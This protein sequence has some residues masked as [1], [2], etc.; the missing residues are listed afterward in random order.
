[1]KRNQRLPWVSV[2]FAVLC[3]TNSHAQTL[4]NPPQTSNLDSGLF[5][6]ILTGE[7]SAQRGDAGT[8]ISLLLDAARKS[9]TPKL[10]ER[11]VEVA[12][13]NRAGDLALQAA[14]A[15]VA[16]M[17]DSREANRY[18]LQILIGLNRLPEVVAP[19][20]RELASLNPEDRAKSLENL[21]RFFSNAT[22]KKLA[23]TVVEQALAAD[24]KNA[25]TGPLAWTIVGSMRLDAADT[26]GALDAAKSGVA[27]DKAAREPI[28][29]ALA[30]LQSNPAGAEGL[31]LDYLKT[32]HD[33]KMQMAYIRRL[34]DAQ[35]FA[36]VGL[37]IQQLTTNAPEFPDAWLVRSSL[38]LQD[39]R[40]AIARLSVNNYLYTM[41][42]MA[43]DI[44]PA[45]RERG[46]V[47]AYFLLS[48]I[49]EMEGNFADAE[50]YLVAI[51]TEQDF[52][53]VQIR[54]ASL[55][56]KQGKLNDAIAL[57]LAIPEKREEDARNKF[58][59]HLQLLRDNGQH[60]AAYALLADVAK[61]RPMDLDLTYELAM[62]AEKI[63]RL[64]EMETYLRQIIAA[65]PEYHSAYNA[66]G[67]VLAD[68]NKRLPEAHA[69]ITK[70]L[71]LAPDNAYILDSLGWV[72]F[73]SGNL[74]KAVQLLQRAFDTKPDAEIAAHLGE[75]LWQ[76]GR[77]L[78]ARAMWTKGLLLNANNE[79]LNET[80]RRLDRP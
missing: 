31:V 35:R 36:D 52:A 80:I 75:V 16:A 65:N 4:A 15:W 64:D 3:V 13:R 53:N 37:Q 44:E 47:Q 41:K 55:L 18:L 71:Q 10:F 27:L 20:K 59:A 22:D 73:R 70:A 66:L 14:Q 48:Q 29:L 39:R 7:L 69:L 61:K 42:R 33:P 26:A 67:Y 76:Q 58:A 12:L 11:A 77:P 24:L 2:L 30:L 51:D 49:A 32:H 25:K 34:T 54:R 56:A 1:M 21:P 50:K 72:E 28:R 19:L 17:P 74:P 63:D 38:E 45:A 40:P 6:Q 23:A 79:T 8:S 57:I 9:S 62:A 68:R 78:E 5:Y 46:L 60:Q 43:A